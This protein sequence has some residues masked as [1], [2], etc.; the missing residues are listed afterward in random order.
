VKPILRSVIDFDGKISQDNLILNL[1]RLVSSKYEW[2]RPDDQR[3]YNFTLSFFQQRMEVPS[4]QTLKDYFERTKDIEAVERVKDLEN[5]SSYIRTNFDELLKNALEEQH[6]IKAVALLKESQE[7][8]T[9]GLEIEGERKHGVR[10]GL[11]H[12]ASRANDLITSEYN[13]RT[14]GDIRD[15]GQDVWND[16]EQAKVNKDKVWGKFTGLNNIDKCCHGAKKGELWVHAAFPGELKTSLAMNWCYNLVT[17]YKTNVFYVSLEMPYAQLRR[18]AYVIHSASAKWPLAG[19]DKPLD[20]RKVRDGMLDPKEEA[21]YKD[22]VADFHRNPDYCSF[23]V[24]SPDREVNID[25]IRLEAE[26]LHKRMEVGLIVL[27]HGM[28]IEA[29]KKKRSKDYVVELNSVIRDSKKLALHFNQGEGIPVLMLFQINRQGKNEADKNEG[30]YKMSALTYA[31]ECCAEGTLV[32]TLR[33]L[34][35]IEDVKPGDRVWSHTGWKDV[36]ARYDNGVREV[37]DLWTNR[38]LRIQVTGNHR[39]RVLNDGRVEWKRVDALTLSDHL[40][41]DFGARPFP[42]T[43]SDL[44]PLVFEK[45]EKPTGRYKTP[46][47]VPERITP[48]L[49][50]VFGAHI[51][52]GTFEPGMV[53]FTGN[54]RESAV[55]GRL[56][57]AFTSC[58]SQTITVSKAPSRPGS[59]DMRKYSKALHRWFDQLRVNRQ[60]GLPPCI[61]EAPRDCVKTFLRGLWDTDGSINNQG[62]L[63]IGLKGTHE[64]TLR[65]TQLL[66]SDL[67]IDTTLSFGLT[68]LR[69][70]EFDRW[71]LRVRSREGRTRFARLI[72][73]TE[74]KKQAK[75]MSFVDCHATSCKAGDRTD[76]PV[77]SLFRSI[78]ERYAGHDFPRKVRNAIHKLARPTT[79]VSDGAVAALLRTL[80][81]E[82]S[83]ELDLLRSLFTST[84]PQRVAV[85]AR[86][87]SSRVFDLEV[88]GDHEYA[89]AGFLSHN[90]EKSADIITTTYLNEEHRRLG[91][92]LL[93]NLKNRDN[94]IFEPFQAEVNFSSRRIRNRNELNTMGGHGMSTE[95]HH[96]VF[97]AMAGIMSGV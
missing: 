27:D 31:N 10:E 56:T 63:A 12:F 52:D 76:W 30:R 91:T 11:Q 62:I 38:G 7:I 43:V 60:P 39:V 26:L 34:R 72:G 1:Q 47:T 48:D 14:R 70:Q 96:G 75:L 86:W 95:E 80:R 3:V 40:L 94:P 77:G 89:T 81:N 93:C 13:A 57:A 45:H 79:L 73:F 19:Y 22:V 97:D 5:V 17:R 54:C 24:W 44:P 42:T 68:K 35:P 55:L 78:F 36:L 23:E 74:P 87:G 37:Y 18:I 4:A 65:Q 85:L 69:G 41:C 8:I 32:K 92:T 21:F 61:L 84:K 82:R 53:G 6:R 15:D 66:M 33:G 88:T 58:F 90:C 46:L 25:D 50:Y 49:A 71:V 2:T 51:G 64:A 9:K 67:G 29:R 59:F 16:Y 28:L 20:Y 83:E